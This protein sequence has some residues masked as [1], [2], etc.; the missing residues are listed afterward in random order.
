MSKRLFVGGLP[1]SVTE[2]QLKEIFSKF[3]E[4]DSVDVILDRY[5][6]QSKGFAFVDMKKDEEAKDAIN[7]LN[8]SE[9]GGRKII[10]SE[11]RPREERQSF[12]DRGNNR[13][14]HKRSRGSRR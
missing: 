5:T 9:V 4:V 1:Y 12:N 13:S 10:V 6:N 3:G 14:Y 7:K 2:N 11:A 8:N